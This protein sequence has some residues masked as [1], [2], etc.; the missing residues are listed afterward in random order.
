M[1]KQEGICC[2]V[3]KYLVYVSCVNCLKLMGEL[4]EIDELI[5]ANEYSVAGNGLIV[6][7]SQ[8]QKNCSFL[9]QN[10]TLFVNEKEKSKT[11]FRVEHSL[12]NKAY[13]L[14]TASQYYIM[15]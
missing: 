6:Q 10:N 15:H 9:L 11:I 3:I 2:K 13:N 7:G 12:N 8:Q 14:T 5:L 1:I 4:I